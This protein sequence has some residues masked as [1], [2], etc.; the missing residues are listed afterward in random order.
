MI[1]RSFLQ[2]AATAPA[3][4]RAEGAAA[5]GQAYLAGQF[6]PSDHVE[7]EAALT[8]MADDASPLVRLALAR[9]FATDARAPHFIVT[10]L[11]SDRPDIAT[12]V[13][14]ASPV[15][16]E[17]ELVDAVA[18]GGPIVQV[19]VARRYRLPAG[20]AAALA[21]VASLPACLALCRN[22]SA[23]VDTTTLG[24]VI[25]RFGHEP[26][27]REALLQRPDLDS[28]LRHDLVVATA[29]ALARFVTDRGWMAPQ[30]VA[31]VM[32]DAQ[33]QACVTI[34]A[35]DARRDGCSGTMRLVAHV[36]ASGRLTPALILRALLCGNTGFFDAAM[37]NLSG[38][39]LGRVAGLARRGRGFGFAALYARAGLPASL[40]P[41]FRAALDDGRSG[42]GDFDRDTGATLQRARI[43][44]VLAAC[45][46]PLTGPPATLTALLRRLHA[47]AA[48]EEA[49]IFVLEVGRDRRDAMPIVPRLSA[50]DRRPAFRSAA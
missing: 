22:A 25:E 3:A 37:S 11:A 29:E 46:D 30:R 50:E 23:A 10:A 41:A 45:A 15:L 5:L 44:R 38:M 4:E 36:R 33:D 48:R 9:V 32:R 7:A 27:L 39:P 21:E 20:V 8:A 49:R 13:L 42:L 40:L 1:I 18:V 17:A 16:C 26:A 35:T 12:L 34:A 43:G 2:W 47:E 6:E 31:R 28:G 19:A 24:R 14:Q